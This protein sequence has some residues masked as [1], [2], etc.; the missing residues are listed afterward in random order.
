MGCCR[1]SADKIQVCG[2][3]KRLG[4]KLAVGSMKVYI[5]IDMAKDKLNYCAI[6]DDLNI[7][8]TGID[9]EN[10]NERFKELSD[11]I[12]ILKSTSTMMK[13][14]M[15]STG[16]YHI[17]LYNHLRAYGFPV[18]IL[19][20]LE[21]RGMKQSIARKTT[22]DT[23]DAESIAR[24]LMISEEKE[25]FVVPENF[26]NLREIITAYSIVSD[27]IRATKNN[28]IRAID[29]I[30]PGLSN[31]IDINE[32]TVDMLSKYVTPE[33]FISADTDEI[34]KYISK[35]RYGK[36]MKIA[37]D[38]PVNITMER[39]LRMEISSLIRI[40]KVLMEEKENIENTMKSDPVLE[41]HVIMS[42]PGI[43]P[44]T[45]S[46][47]PGK[48]C[49]INRF[50]NAEKLVAFAGIDPV[51]KESGKQRSHKSISKRG[52]SALRS[53]I[54][55]STL[56]AIR[57]NPVISEFYHRKVD[58]GMPKKKALVAASRKQ[59]HIIWSVWHNNKP[60]EIPERFRK[61][62]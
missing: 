42:I 45:G 44:I 61:Q 27:K 14:G 21:V 8:F 2:E 54:Y 47:I 36:I 6:S 4:E 19:N 15:E 26:I 12:R 50:E 23:I 37:S 18:R 5:G 25:T 56:A 41:N 31:A 9:K 10:K 24:Y 33:D 32:D 22:N 3:W 17:P 39:S 46:V 59:C 62:E 29:M 16:I 38:S 51:I 20:G 57:G 7:L 48:I 55:Q 58:G 30:F 43:G 52:D 1:I 13:I 34:E 11:L 49:D 35:R 60:F 40:L 28:L 53:A